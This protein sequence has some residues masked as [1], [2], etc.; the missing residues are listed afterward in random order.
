MP[1]EKNHPEQGISRRQLLKALAAASGAIAASSLLPEKWSSPALEV[2]V[3][4]AHAQVS[5]EPISITFYQCLARDIRTGEGIA[6][7]FSTVETETYITPIHTDILLK[8]TIRHLAVDGDILLE[9]TGYADAT[10]LFNPPNIDVGQMNTDNGNVLSHGDL[11]YVLW[12]VADPE[13][14]SNS[15]INTLTYEVPN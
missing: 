13:I 1:E 11:L 4:P 12:E 2:G 3:L 15:C 14:E 6:Y 5:E 9:T 10:G 7:S 8:R